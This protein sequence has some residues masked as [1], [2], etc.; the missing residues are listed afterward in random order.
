MRRNESIFWLYN[1]PYMYI[2]L[3]ISHP[4]FFIRFLEH[5]ALFSLGRQ[6]YIELLPL[7]SWFLIHIHININMIG[8]VN[9]TL[10]IRVKNIQKNHFIVTYYGH[11]APCL[12]GADRRRI[13]DLMH[14]YIYWVHFFVHRLTLL[15]LMHLTHI[16]PSFTTRT[17]TYNRYV[18]VCVCVM[19]TN[20]YE[21][22][23]PRSKETYL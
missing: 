5:C 12:R 8:Q 17:H 14:L 20:H 18:C 23:A 13:K 4:L 10:A 15:S 1:C 22:E 6:I 21:L 9:S 16:Y 3:L 7:H 11:F 2:P 19:Y